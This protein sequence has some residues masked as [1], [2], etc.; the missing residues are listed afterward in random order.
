MT[1]AVLLSAAVVQGFAAKWGVPAY[2]ADDSEFNAGDI[3]DDGLFWDGNAMSAD[4]IQSF[5]NSKEP[6]CQAGYTCLKSYVQT[7]YTIPATPMCSQYNGAANESAAQIIAKVAESCG[8]SPKVI[9]V[10]LQKEEGLI[11]STAPTAGAYQS[12]MG[13]G[14]PDTS[15]CDTNYYGFFNQ[16]HYGSYLLRRYTD[17]AG[18]G[19]GTA[20][21][22]QFNLRYPVGQTTAILKNPNAACGTI[23]VDVQDEATH[24]LYVYTP[25]TP[26]Q[27]ALNAG[28]GL[29]DS[30]SSYGNRNFYNYFVDWFGTVRGYDVAPQFT[31]AYTDYG[32]APGFLE[33]PT[34]PYT[35][36]LTQSACYQAYDGG[37]IVQGPAGTIG[38]PNLVLEAWS[39]YGRDTTS[40]LGFPSGP[41]T[42]LVGV[43]YTTGTYT[44]AFQNGLITVTNGVPALTS[45]TDP[46]YETLLTSPWLGASTQAKSCTLKG[47]ACY[48][49]FQNGWLVQSPAG[50]FAISNAVLTA[51]NWY[52]R[53]TTSILGFPSGPPS[54][55]PTSG[56]YTQAFQNGLITVTNGTPTVSSISN[57]W[58]NAQS[59]SPWLGAQTQ[60][61]SC[62]LTGGACYEVFQNGWIIQST[63]G[64]FAISNAVLT[65]W[66][67]YGRD[68]TGVLGYPT[69]AASASPTTGNYTQAFQGGTVAVSG[70]TPTVRLG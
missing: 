5:L 4:Q 44:Q 28:Y 68:V 36:T 61:M 48:Q 21:P 37:W 64:T 46:W 67:W 52:G 35:C 9:L 66:G 12:A 14:C 60:P 70:G 19:P 33:Y 1:C 51:W 32:G 31:S 65:A 49:A 34:S 47:G 13:A 25:Y 6:S 54:A 38:V 8:V 11:T 62:T 30:C 43:S 29:G 63:G 7:T 69:A 22:T 10:T 42:G 2:A 17:P 56:N 16:V 53:D 23:P 26:D 45:T 59:I 50:T 24:S 20:Y 41:P 18:T 27:A 57:P 3:V 58:F 40:I 39:W 15:A 55:S